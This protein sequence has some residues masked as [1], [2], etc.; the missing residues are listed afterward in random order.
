MGCTG[1]HT[2]G[3][4]CRSSAFW[5]AYDVL[6]IVTTGLEKYMGRMEPHEIKKLRADIPCI[7]E[8]RTITRKIGGFCR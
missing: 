4:R 5:E 2:E 7:E 3:C 8:L 6:K 1:P